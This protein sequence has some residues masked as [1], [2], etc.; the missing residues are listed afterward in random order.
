MKREFRYEIVDR[1][2]YLSASAR[3]AGEKAFG[4]PAGLSLAPDACFWPESRRRSE[5]A[6]P[7]VGVSGDSV[8]RGL[9]RSKRT[10]ALPDGVA[11][12]AHPARPRTIG[13]RFC[14]TDRDRLS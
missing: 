1:E 11:P 10:K 9:S 8:A 3:A 13:G 14:L 12:A 2:I 7:P 6:L 4:R 5:W